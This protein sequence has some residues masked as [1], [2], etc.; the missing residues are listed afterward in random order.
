M[1]TTT[2]I[3][4]PAIA[5]K[6]VN[7]GSKFNAIATSISSIFSSA[8]PIV[9]AVIPNKGINP[10][11]PGAYNPL[12]SSGGALPPAPLEPKKDNTLLYVGLGIGA[13]ILGAGGFL[14]LKRKKSKGVSGLGCPET[15]ATPA[16]NGVK[17]SRKRKKSTAKKVRI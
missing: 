17:K 1:I 15:E 6:P 3:N 5:A 9:Q 13:A 4:I 10:G 16:L 7:D 8:A 14:L 11:G 2:P 12:P